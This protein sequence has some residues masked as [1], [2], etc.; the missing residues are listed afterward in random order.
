M[1]QLSE[2]G[3]ETSLQGLERDMDLLDE[4]AAIEEEWK[5]KIRLVGE[6]Q[7]YKDDMFTVVS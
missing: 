5:S 3:N 4:F 2:D 1:V 6:H 7:G